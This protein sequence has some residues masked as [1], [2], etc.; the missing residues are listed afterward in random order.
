LTALMMLSLR[1]LLPRSALSRVLKN[2]WGRSKTPRGV[3]KPGSTLKIKVTYG[4]RRRSD[5]SHQHLAC[6]SYHSTPSLA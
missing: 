3:S 5:D 4:S 1:A 2:C 6:S